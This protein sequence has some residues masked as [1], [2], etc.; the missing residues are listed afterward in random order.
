[1]LFV[2]GSILTFGAG[3]VFAHEFGLGIG[4]LLGVVSVFFGA[5]SGATAGFLIARFVLREWVQN[6]AKKYAIFEA[7][8]AALAEKGFRI[9]T[10]IRL[11]PIIPFSATNYI[12]GITSLSF[13]DYEMAL[14]FIL[15]GTI[16]YVFLGASAGSLTASAS[17][18][19]LNFRITIPVIVV[20]VILGVLA[21]GLTSYYA[22]KELNRVLE[23]RRLEQEGQQV[24]DEEAQ[25]VEEQPHA[26]VETEETVNDETQ[27]VDKRLPQT[28]RIDEDEEE[29][30]QERFLDVALGDEDAS[31][32]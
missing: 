7:L 18:G 30:V 3:F 16:L 24:G 2:P 28:E 5:Y 32:A 9:M 10:L 21:V 31:D 8:E 23:K 11:S 26:D 17:S 4:V 14:F 19:D 13:R 20:G 15:P 27:D 1:M 29:P 12:A 22:K 6:F 25:E